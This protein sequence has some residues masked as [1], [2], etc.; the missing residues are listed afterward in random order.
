MAAYYWVGGT[1][2]W[3]TTALGKW[4]NSDGGLPFYTTAPGV[5]DDVF[6]T[7]LSG[8]GLVTLAGANIRSL[9]FTGFLGEFRFA[10]SLTINSGTLTLGAGATYSTNA[11]VTS[12]TLTV[13][14]TSP[15][16]VSNSK[17]LPVNLFITNSSGFFT[18]TGNADFQGNLLTSSG[19]HNIKAAATT[20]VDLRIGGNITLGATVVNATD[21]ITIKAYGISKTYNSNSVCGNIRVVFVA[22]SV[23]S[24]NG[25]AGLTGASFLTVET[26]GRFNALSGNTFSN[27]GTVTLSGFNAS[28]NSDFY[29][30]A[31]AVTFTCLTDIVIKSSITI[32][33]QGTSIACSGASKLLLEGNFASTGG[34]TIAID[35]L[36]FSGTTLSTVSAVTANNLF[37]RDLSF[38]KT[39]AGSVNF[40]S[41]EFRLFIPSSFTYT[42]THTSG[43]IT[44]SPT[45]VIRIEYGGPA[46]TLIYSESISL[47]T[48][49]TIN[50]LVLA[51]GILQ[52][53]SPLRATTLRPAGTGMTFTGTAGW[54]CGTLLYSVPG[55]FIVL[56]SG[57]T[58]TTTTN[59]VMLGTNA[60]KIL[61]RSSAPTVSYAIWTLQNP[62]S[63]SMVYVSA[64]AIDSSLGMTIY[65]FGGII[66]TAAPVPT[67]NW[68]LGA[69]QGTKAFTFVN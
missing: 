35:R 48:P 24:S 68:A 6:F 56:Q 34:A 28:N 51:A 45:S 33:T 4:S 26:G 38:N 61:M 3:N 21:Y 58:Y 37:I 41:T 59:V 2:T 40:T 31:G 42:W 16:L 67:L 5:A 69:A 23:Y 64:T 52:L 29:G 1:N 47:S 17:I 44:Y 7:A 53:N 57:I 43:A 50:S 18:I 22:G 27:G 11:T 54:T 10:G 63:Q 14:G 9:D 49:S 66:S 46:S 30:T 13:Q 55:G 32:T 20:T 8:T 39:G 19:A 60:A 65:S 12:Y 36:E 25:N 15:G 62:A